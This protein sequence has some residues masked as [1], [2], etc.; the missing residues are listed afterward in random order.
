M[1]STAPESPRLVADNGSV[2]LDRPGAGV[3]VILRGARLT[4]GEDI[5]DVSAA[6]RIRKPYL[7]AIEEG[8]VEDLPGLTYAIGFVRAYAEYLDLDIDETVA[9]FK[10]ESSRIDIKTQ[11][12][13]PEP[14]PGN[15]VP[16]GALLIV[17]LFFAAAA[18]GGYLYKSSKEMTFLEAVEAV[19]ADLLALIDGDRTEAPTPAP[20]A[21]IVEEEDSAPALE[22]TSAAVTQETEE[23]NPIQAE[24]SVS[25]QSDPSGTSSASETAEPETGPVSETAE[26]TS[27]QPVL[28]TTTGTEDPVSEPNASELGQTEIAETPAT[29]EPTTETSIEDVPEET[30]P[31]QTVQDSA[32]P[33]EVATPSTSTSE[34]AENDI[35]V[36]ELP[37]PTPEPFVDPEPDQPAT[38]VT[39]TVIGGIVATEL[40]PPPVPETAPETAQETAP[41]TALEPGPVD[42]AETAVD[43]PQASQSTPQVDTASAPA[44]LRIIIQATNEVWVKVSDSDGSAI[45]EKLM[46]M[47][48]IYRVPNQPGL[49][50][51][52]GNAGALKLIVNGTM[53]PSL[54]EI[55]EV[56]RGIVLS[57]EAL[58]G[59]SG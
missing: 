4:R 19:P 45:I 42:V 26:E 47:G 25:E 5:Q 49:V 31:P 44:E 20:A 41:G 29:E 30:S 59:D 58:L 53:A 33:E 2:D 9:R 32:P 13:F 56:R 48:E 54:G 22:E 8:R 14:L 35:S 16:G 24:P 55:G 3:G 37:A 12:Q 36:T 28:D 43:Q 50:M 10:D 7:E 34:T 51:E 15:R 46:L 27:P 39:E 52:T 11:L 57:K 40:P 38:S 18:Y 1:A 23:P 6:L 17:A 21:P